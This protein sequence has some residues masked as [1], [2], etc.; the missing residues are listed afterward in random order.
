MNTYPRRGFLSCVAAGL[1]AT[2]PWHGSLAREEA[3][4]PSQEP[5]R[6]ADVPGVFQIEVDDETGSP[7]WARLE[8]R[9]PEGKMY[10]PE[11]ALTDRTVLDFAGIGPWYRGGFVA[12][13]KTVV[14]VPAGTYT[15]VAEHGT[16]YERYE[17]QVVVDAGQSLPLKITLKPWVRMNELGWWSA[18][19]HVHRDLEGMPK[20]ALAE[21]LNLSVVY[22]LWNKTNRWDGKEWPKNPVIEVTPKHLVTMLNGEDER[23][24]GA[25]LLEGLQKNLNLAV[26]GRWYPPGIDFVRQARAQRTGSSPMPWFDCEKPFWWEVPVLMALE[27]PD[28]MGLVHNH[29]T[30]YGMLANE[31][32]GH[33]RD[34][35]KYPGAQGFVHNSLDLY[36]RYLNLGL[37]VLPSAGSASGVLPNPV[38]YN[39]CYV[40]LG[41]PFSVDA[42]YEG[43]QSGP[44][45]VTNGPML[46]VNTR[47]LPGKKVYVAVEARAREP[48]D[49]IEIVAN[50]QLIEQMS[51]SQGQRS[52]QAERTLEAGRHTW[53]AVRCYV[54][55]SSTI[56]LGHSRPLPLPGTFNSRDDALFFV[57]WLDELVDQ[58]RADTGRFKTPAERDRVLGLYAQARQFYADKAAEAAASP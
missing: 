21:G 49:R 36:Y 9:G 54:Q 7:V 44:S 2:W 40:K 39:R 55:S 19:F 30:Q 41:K 58:T 22:T 56:R 51:P 38:G 50:G 13:G 28:S 1:A 11:S 12:K 8:I 5:A 45:F 20:L 17:K 46:F 18:D 53:L 31:A 26:D 37:M 16:E 42:W 3:A 35:Q 24:G 34:R 10:E 33:P 52:F 32:W 14:E 23:G 4:S 15:V 29:F 47:N 57:R 48:L 6:Q 25:W 43:F 27:R